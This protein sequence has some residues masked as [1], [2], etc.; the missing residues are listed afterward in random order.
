MDQEQAIT[1]A[2]QFADTAH[3]VEVEKLAHKAQEQLAAMKNR[4]AAQG[5]LLSG[6]TVAETARIRGEQ[7]TAMLENRLNLLLE[8]FD[9]HQVVIDDNVKDRVVAELTA[10]RTAWITNALEAMKH[11]HVLRTGPVQHAHF[12]PLLAKSVGLHPNEVRTK[13][14]RARLTRKKAE[15]NTSVNIY[16]VSG[17]NNRWLTNSQD[18][19]VN[20]ITQSSD[21]I[22]VTLRQQIE[23]KVPAGDEQRDIL[24][25]LAALEQS[26]N[27]PSF[28]Q[29]YT[30]FIAA[31]ANHMQLVCPFIPAITE[32]LR[33]AL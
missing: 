9:L 18:H 5:T 15:A 17:N 27:T 4:L 8:G 19:S 11:D 26:Q 7:V 24:E 23:S 12:L 16:H 22:F 6:T 13:V 1:K 30:E 31:A 20:I 33:K 14:E 3:N 21:Q 32:M 10:L 28:S 25:R 2:R 29:R